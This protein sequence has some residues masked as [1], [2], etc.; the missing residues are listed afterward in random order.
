MADPE[1]FPESPSRLASSSSYGPSDEELTDREGASDVGDGGSPE[2]KRRCPDNEATWHKHLRQLKLFV[3]RERRFPRLRECDDE[4]WAIGKWC[5]VQRSKHDKLPAARVEALEEVMGWQWDVRDEIWHKKLERLKEFVARKGRQPRAQEYDYDGWAIGAWCIT[6][7]YNYDDMPAAR[8]EALEEVSGWQWDARDE[9]WHK[10]LE[11]YKTFVAR[12]GRQPKCIE[13]DVDGWAISNW[14]R[15]Q[16]YSC[17]N[18][19]LAAE[20][21][22]ALDDVPGWRW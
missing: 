19:K 4:G 10:H 18:G 21:I 9:N 2:P 5:S 14:C 12:E 11:Q 15:Y 1:S 3:A 8:V 6:Q 13:Y 7:K 16:R 22:K 17:K 20:R